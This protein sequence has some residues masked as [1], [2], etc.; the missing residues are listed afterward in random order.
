M[1]TATLVASFDRQRPTAVIG[2]AWSQF[3]ACADRAAS[4]LA[5][6]TALVN[7][8]ASDDSAAVM[9]RTRIPIPL[10]SRLLSRW[11]QLLM[12]LSILE[13][14]PEMADLVKPLIL[15]EVFCSGD[16]RYL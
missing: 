14:L 8:E 11:S 9:I 15:I 16:P 13:S 3:P 5:C 12:T 10:F 6:D 7:F 4:S 2:G 1:P